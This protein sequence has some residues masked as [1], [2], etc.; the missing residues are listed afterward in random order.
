MYF[1]SQPIVNE[2]EAVALTATWMPDWVN[3]IAEPFAQT[4]WSHGSCL[5]EIW[6]G[7]LPWEKHILFGVDEYG[8]HNIDER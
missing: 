8:N 5:S 4:F 1:C 3:N 6:K 2:Q 7:S